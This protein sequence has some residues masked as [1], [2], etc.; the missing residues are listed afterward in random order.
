MLGLGWLIYFSFGMVMSSLVPIVTLLR[1]ELGISFTQMG[2]ILGAWQLVYIAA[3]APSGLLIDR[4]GPKK[5]LAIGALIIALSA[6]LRSYAEGFWSLFAAV[7]LFGV[8]GP[9]VSIGLPKLVVDWFSGPN[10][11][12]ASGIYITGPAL[13]SVLVLASTHALI[14]PLTGSWRLTLALYA[15]IALIVAALWVAFGRDSAENASDRERSGAFIGGYREVIFQPAVWTVIVVGFSAFL[16]SHGLRSWLPQILEARGMSPALSGVLASLPAL[17]GVLGSIFIL[18][19]ASRGAGSRRRATL[20]LLLVTGFCVAAIT[21][22]DGWALVAAIAVEGFCAA[23][24]QP[25]MLYILMEMP[26]VGPRRMGTAAGIFFSVG[27][28]G[29]TLGPVFMGLIADLTGSFAPGLLGIAAIMWIM[30]AP[31][32]RIRA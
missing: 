25:L 31:A 8:G 12:L 5:A 27:E 29:G 10:R 6:F 9:I 18:G 3:A 20:A 32:L 16:A 21:F 13:G 19:L 17:T 30:L 22:L 14:L 24:I 23:A 4:I 11:G 26:S 1:D 28:V 7:A 15:V 2:V